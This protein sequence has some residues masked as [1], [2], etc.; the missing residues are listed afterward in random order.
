M[1]CPDLEI[2]DISDCESITDAAIASLMQCR[3]L[4]KLNL[5]GNDQLT[6][7]AFAGLSERCWPKMESLDLSDCLKISDKSMLQIADHCP[8]FEELVVF[9]NDRIT[10]ESLEVLGTKCLKLKKVS[11]KSLDQESMDSLQLHFPHIDWYFEEDE[12]GFEEFDLR[13]L[14][15]RRN[16]KKFPWNRIRV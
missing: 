4:K 15:R 1:S 9:G 2:L 13:K 5:S 14:L 11:M 10:A 8:A 3:A 12:E 7:A 6:D 16:S